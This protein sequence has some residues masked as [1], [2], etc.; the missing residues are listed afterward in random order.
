[1]NKQCTE[2]NAIPSCNLKHSN[3]FYHNWNEPYSILLKTGKV[4]LGRT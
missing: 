2:I 4:L 3:K 1:M